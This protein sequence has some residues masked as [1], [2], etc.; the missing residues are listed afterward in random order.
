MVPLERLTLEHY[1]HH[2][3]KYCQGDRF[4][5]DFQLHEVEWASVSVEADSVGWN[6]CAILKEGNAP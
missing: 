5:D 2:D 1:G 3:C 4:L 6:L